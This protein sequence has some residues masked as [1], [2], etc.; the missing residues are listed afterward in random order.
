[1]W[2]GTPCNDCGVFNEQERI[3]IDLQSNS[4]W[5]GT[6]KIARPLNGWYA[7]ATSYKYA[8][9]GGTSP[10][11]VWNRTAFTTRDE[12]IEAAALELKRKF[13]GIRDRKGYAPDSQRQTAQRMIGQI[14]T[15]MRQ[16]RQMT[17]F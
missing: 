17:L 8:I 14:E 15:F 6:I 7:V 12:A 16:S 3:D 5:R 4:Q 13:E 10:I 1:M 9:G 11:S 2:G